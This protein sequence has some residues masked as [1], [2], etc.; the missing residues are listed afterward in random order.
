MQDWHNGMAW[1]KPCIGRC[2][3]F[4][5][6]ITNTEILPK[7]HFNC[8]CIVTYVAGSFFPHSIGCVYLFSATYM[9]ELSFPWCTGNSEALLLVSVIGFAVKGPSVSWISSCLKQLSLTHDGIEFWNCVAWAACSTIGIQ[10]TV[11]LGCEAI[12]SILHLL[13]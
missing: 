11:F 5:I 6:L 2:E 9:T 1:L 3:F 13:R 4:A 7:Y 8:S 12:L 10:V